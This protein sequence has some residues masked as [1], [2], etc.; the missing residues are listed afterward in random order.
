MILVPSRTPQNSGYDVYANAVRV[1][2]SVVICYMSITCICLYMLL[3]VIC[4]LYVRGL[5]T[6]L[7]T[8]AY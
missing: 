7:F 6:L 8:S 5:S 3:Y 1:S 2:Y 4:L